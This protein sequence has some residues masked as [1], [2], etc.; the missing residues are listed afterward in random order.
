MR[1]LLLAFMGV[2]TLFTVFTVFFDSAGWQFGCK[3]RFVNVRD[4]MLLEFMV[5]F[6]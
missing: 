1:S 2:F 4:T 3:N 5:S 6:A